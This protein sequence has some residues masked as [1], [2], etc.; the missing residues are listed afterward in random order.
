MTVS[1]STPPIDHATAWSAINSIRVLA[2]DAVEAANSG[3]P[4]TPMALA[5][6]AWVLWTRHLKHAP[7]TPDWFDRDRFVLSCGHASMLLYSLLHLTGYDLPLEELK[8]FRQWGSKT[9]GH[10][11]RGHTVGVEVTT[12][13][14]GQGIGNGVGMAMAERLL[15]EQF[16][17]A[18]CD[19]RTWVIASDGDMMEGVS[20]EAASLAGHLQLDRL[21]VIWDDNKITIDGRTE[22]AFTEDVA[23]RYRAYGWHVLHVRDGNDLADIDIALASAASHHD[24]PT[25]IAINTI[26][27]DPAPTKRDTSAAHG[28]PLGATEIAATKQI[29]GWPETPFHLP[30]EVYQT[31]ETLRANGIAL[32]AEW[33]QRVAALP[34]SID[35]R[36]QLA[37]ELPADWHAALP[38]L[39]A[40]SVATRQAS[41]QALQALVQAVPGMVGGS[42]DLGGSNGTRVKH[43]EA[44]TATVTGPRI[45]WGVR[46]HGMAAAM[47]G[48]AAHGGVRPYGATFLVFADYCK[49]SIRLAALMGLPVIYIFTHDSIGVGEDGPTHQPV[50]HLAMLRGIPNLVTL[51]PGDAAETVEAWC[52]AIQRTDGPTAL[53]LTR[54]TLPAINRQADAVSEAARGGYIAHEPAASPRAVL[55]ATGSELS[56]AMDAARA[57]E[58]EGTPTRVV[59]LPSWELFAAQDDAWR[60][61]VLPRALTARV[62]IEAGSTFGWCRWVGDR[63]TALGLDHFGASAPAERLFAEFGLT[64]E[65][66]ADAVRALL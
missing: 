50:E 15:R 25:L 7:D 34:N 39:A 37:G 63:G 40:T 64:P 5:P 28:A 62:S 16:G 47:N 3:H 30:V 61:R 18:V 66:A 56:V 19:H 13:P 45:N 20:S 24:A 31:G 26:I 55:I 43:G 53:I 1:A 36:Q 10:P 4:G 35:F 6:A 32:V 17:A 9:P 49:P 29:L 2:M 11:E 65:H 46:E 48:M 12:G 38:D 58:A 21:C 42:A 60:E 51:R 41:Q 57:L 52:A 27:A 59:S 33:Q 22:L 14:L 8:Q 23:A 44:M 54:Q